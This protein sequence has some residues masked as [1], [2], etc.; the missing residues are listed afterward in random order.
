MAF[1]RLCLISRGEGQ[2]ASRDEKSPGNLEVV[3]RYNRTYSQV[4]QGKVEP[5]KDR[6]NGL[7][8]NLRGALNH[9]LQDLARRRDL[10]ARTAEIAFNQPKPSPVEQLHRANQVYLARQALGGQVGTGNSS[11]E[12]GALRRGPFGIARKR[13]HSPAQS[14]QSRESLDQV[15]L[16]RAPALQAGRQPS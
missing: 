6:P 3:G 14:V 5:F 15:P 2:V 13:L 8:L 16:R 11:L 9:T 10:P 4:L 1:V 12:L 7:R